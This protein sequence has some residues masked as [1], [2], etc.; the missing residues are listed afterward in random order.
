MAQLEEN[1]SSKG[2]SQKDPS[3]FRMEIVVL[4]SQVAAYRNSLT[5][6]GLWL[7][8]SK[9]GFWSTGRWGSD[10]GEVIENE[11]LPFELQKDNELPSQSSRNIN[12]YQNQIDVN[13]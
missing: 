9:L 8:F 10:F 1:L 4:N 5:N 2:E 13:F 6:D 12:S 7:T 11:V 3:L